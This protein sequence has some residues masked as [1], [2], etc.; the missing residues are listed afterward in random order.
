MTQLFRYQRKGVYLLD[1]FKGRALLADEMGLGKS[2]QSLT[3][4]TKHDAFPTLILCPAAVKWHWQSELR[5]HF[6][7]TSEILEGRSP[8][9]RRRDLLTSKVTIAN[10]DIIEAWFNYLQ[11][12][13]AKLIILDEAQYLTNPQAKR[14][15]LSQRLTK[16]SPHVIACTGTPLTNRP[17]ELW[18][19]LSM[20]RPDKFKRFRKFAK[21]YC[22]P[23]L[24]PWGWKFDG[25]ENV[26]ELRSMLYRHLM[27]RRK[28]K[29]VLKDLPPKQIHPV[30]IEIPRKEM[31]QYQDAES[32][33][34]SW[35]RRTRGAHKAKRARTAE[36]MV[37]FGYLRRLAARLKID[38]IGEWIDD[39]LR[40]SE[41]KL[42]IFGVHR[43]ILQ[44]LHQKYQSLSVIID[45][46]VTGKRRK[47]SITK[48]KR[49]SHCRLLFANNKA[50]GIGVNYV[51]ASTSLFAE[52][53]WT[54]ADVDQAIDR[55][56]RIGQT[57]PVQSFLL[58]ARDTV[59]ERLYKI[60]VKKQ[61]LLQSVLDGDGKIRKRNVF[62]LLEK[63]Y[64]K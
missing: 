62:E 13:D 45:G 39:F 32:D 7:L 37:R 31:K 26:D 21:R 49:S 61:R 36:R 20:I 28:K 34:I 54:S 22:D 50:G 17:K 3:W 23:E 51:E 40:D 52:L 42:V 27:I 9:K 58:I 30:R 16:K 6:G 35:L 19:L 5:D 12:Y 11:R 8:P 15:R 53:P 43:N 4:M 24:T 60:L 44:P 46:S 10:Y 47:H 25:A 55:Q 63:E 2:I 38:L 59:E 64:L 57:H 56:H 33:F 41:Q 1:R 14:T 18:P 48:F 29:H